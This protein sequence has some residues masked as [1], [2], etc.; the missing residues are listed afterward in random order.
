MADLDVRNVPDLAQAN[1]FD[2]D[3]FVQLVQAGRF[4]DFSVL[5][6][7]QLFSTSLVKNGTEAPSSSDVIANT[8]VWYI[9]TTN[10]TL[11]IS[12][13]GA[14]FISI[15]GGSPSN[16]DGW[17]PLF[18]IESDGARRVLKVVDWTGGSGTKP[19]INQYLTASGFDT[20][21]TNAVDIRGPVGGTGIDGTGGW[22]PEIAIESDSARRVLK[23][24]DWT[25]GSGTKPDIDQYL[26]ASGFGTDIAN[27]IDIRGPV[28][29]DGEDGGSGL[30][31]NVAIRPPTASDVVESTD[32]LWF[33][34]TR[35]ALYISIDGGTWQNIIPPTA[36]GERIATSDAV[37]YSV[38]SPGATD[39]T[40]GQILWTTDGTTLKISEEDGETAPNTQTWGFIGAGDQIWIGGEGVF[41][42]SGTPTRETTG[43]AFWEFTGRWLRRDDGLSGSDVVV[44][45]I[46]VERSVKERS[47]EDL[48]IAPNSVGSYELKN[49]SVGTPELADGAIQPGTSIDLGEW[50]RTSNLQPSSNGRFYNT[51]TTFLLYYTNNGGTDQET[52]LRTIRPGDRLYFAANLNMFKVSAVVFSN[53]HAT[54]TGTWAGTT[55]TQGTY[56][57]NPLGLYLVREANHI[58][59][60]QMISTRIAVVQS[61]YSVR[62]ELFSSQSDE[63]TTPE[64]VE[65]AS[66]V[67]TIFGTWTWGSASIPNTGGFYVDS[68]GITFNNQD[69]DGND[70][71][72]NIT[73]LEVGDRL[74]IGEVNALDITAEAV[75]GTGNSNFVSG[76]W[77]STFDAGDF[78][79]N[80]VIR[81][82]KKNNIVVQG[83]VKR[84]GVLRVGHN[85]SIEATDSDDS[86]VSL[87]DGTIGT[88]EV[89]TNYDINAGELFS[90]YTHVI[91]NFTGS[92]YRN[93]HEIP[94]KVWESLGRVE[95]SNK[96]NC[97][98]VRRMDN[99]TFRVEALTGTIRLRKIHGYKGV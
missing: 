42:A 8:T 79:G 54:F 32:Y 18:A 77:E 72:S 52:A 71:A 66:G 69:A 70:K 91:F 67:Y 9:N 16:G 37:N 13:G 24:V 20:D 68:S 31:L 89:D 25:G 22:S 5:L 7:R 28:G 64:T 86:I 60:N 75:G 44:E 74:Q 29:E 3:V 39:P 51:S 14:A 27:A 48:H 53:G 41:R 2:S 45:Y 57:E 58:G 88:N 17:T 96:D 97:L 98:T 26:T 23:V 85:L 36:I 62:W 15:A 10:N 33:D 93:L 81:I 87:W 73:A 83:N 59:D 43:A 4:R 82:I 94:V 40:S 65:I 55:P 30:T 80:T 47:I 34:Q 11:Y 90:D 49:Q 12:L 92:S 56:G 84:G 6:L 50:Q 19:D 99:N 38:Q 1:I 21:I 63:G 95:V 76:D 78:N 35:D 61:D 46:H